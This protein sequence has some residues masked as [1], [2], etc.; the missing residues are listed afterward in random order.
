MNGLS[1]LNGLLLCFY[2]NATVTQPC[3]RSWEGNGCYDVVKFEALD[4]RS[5]YH[6]TLAAIR[7]KSVT[8]VFLGHFHTDD[9]VD[10]D[11]SPRERRVTCLIPMTAR[12]L[13]TW[14]RTCSPYH[15]W[16]WT[17]S[18]MLELED[19]IAV[20]AQRELRKKKMWPHPIICDTRNNGL[21]WIIFED[22]RRDK[23]K[24]F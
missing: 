19:I 9:P 15:L 12:N 23:A 10:G 22:L 7:S 24:F 21:F 14:R 4:I 8:A 3:N 2:S 18:T 6:S 17:L 16:K 13:S 20:W 11:L 1:E 5:V